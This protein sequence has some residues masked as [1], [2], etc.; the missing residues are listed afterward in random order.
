MVREIVAVALVLD[1]APMVTLF[2]QEDRQ[3]LY[4]Y[5]GI[6]VGIMMITS[7]IPVMLSYMQSSSYQILSMELLSSFELIL[8]Q[9]ITLDAFEEFLANEG[10]G[11][12]YLEVYL[13]CKCFQDMGDKEIGD[14]TIR[15]T[16]N[17]GIYPWFFNA[18]K[19]GMELEDENSL[20]NLMDHCYREL[21][22]E[23]FPRFSLS[24]Q[25]KWL[26]QVIRRQE[27]FNNCISETSFLPSGDME[28][29]R[30]SMISMIKQ[31][32]D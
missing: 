26:K 8:Q 32:A 2:V 23:Y 5:L 28:S 21:K 25:Y 6:N 1:I 10:E 14:K 12:D 30:A 11:A 31:Y 7:G 20:N 9:R 29:V 4:F 19:L 13:G 22:E 17:S 24:T 15:K 27:I 16:R 18:N 3:W